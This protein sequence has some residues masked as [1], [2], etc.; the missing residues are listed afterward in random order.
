M[1]T[2]P[3]KHQNRRFGAPNLTRPNAGPP[4]GCPTV[5]LREPPFQEPGEG[6]SIPSPLPVFKT[7][8]TRSHA[9]S[10]LTNLKQV[11]A[12]LTFSLPTFQPSTPLIPLVS[13]H[14]KALQTKI[15]ISRLP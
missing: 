4:A 14:F 2:N 1:K 3:S 15:F 7:P 13:K 5:P 6:F 11:N 12:P 9:Q 10:H 8:V